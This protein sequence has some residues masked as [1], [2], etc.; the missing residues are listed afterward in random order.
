MSLKEK[1]K[2]WLD[3]RWN[4]E[5]QCDVFDGLNR[6]EIN[7]IA[8]K[9]NIDT[10]ASRLYIC[11]ELAKILQAKKQEYERVLKENLCANTMDPISGTDVADIDPREVLTIYQNGQ[12]YCFEIE[13][14]YKNIFVNN[15]PKNPY[16]NV[17]FDEDSLKTIESEYEK[18]KI[19][20][21]KKFDKYAYASDTTLSALV[22]QLS[23]Y[24]PYTVGIDRFLKA[25][26][27]SINNF[28]NVLLEGYNIVIPSGWGIFPQVVTTPVEEDIQLREYK[29][30]I[31][32]ELIKW[33]VANDYMPVREAW[34][35]TF[36]DES[37]LSA[38][39]IMAVFNNESIAQVDS[40]VR[41]GADL[42]I[43]DGNGLSLLHVAVIYKASIQ[44]IQYLIENGVNINSRDFTRGSSPIMYAIENNSY[45][46]VK[47][48]IQSG[49][50]LQQMNLAAESPLYMAS[51][52]GNRDMILLLLDKLEYVD[53][54]SVDV[55]IGNIIE[56]NDLQLLEILFEKDVYIDTRVDSET[57]E[58]PLMFAIKMNSDDT[59]I[60]FLIKKG[61]SM[62]ARDA[63]GNTPLHIALRYGKDSYIETLIQLSDVNTHNN[64]GQTPLM[65][66][67]L[68]RD[69]D[70]ISSVLNKTD[71]VFALDAKNNSA[72][73]YAVLVDNV[74]AAFLLIDKG[75]DITGKNIYGEDA[76][77]LAK[78]D[79]MVAL[80]KSYVSSS[81]M[82]YTIQ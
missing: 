22:N 50:D 59:L 3:P 62:E 53:D 38:Q 57:E 4:Y 23:N 27:L 32:Q 78:S 33:I 43:L 46:V 29:I 48:L 40:L 68:Y 7:R 66:A 65:L 69:I 70:I 77:A 35:D 9:Y 44:L 16:T 15:N 5:I 55:I 61:A 19:I 26:R 67:C 36:Q 73:V 34:L 6:E 76:L 82:D 31:V 12:Q 74:D 64:E 63:E 71:D 79:E 24:L 42:D 11:N 30:K 51:T 52:T 37:Q 56:M 39:L 21:G 75:S 54:P 80:L 1:L 18:F 45:D 81:A 8:A 72:L 47:L 60:D 10:S 49:A 13:G 25:S 41:Q 17:P 14:I 58:T 2:N 20:R 28:L